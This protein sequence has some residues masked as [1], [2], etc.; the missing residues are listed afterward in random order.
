MTSSEATRAAPPA[1]APARAPAFSWALVVAVVLAAINL[2]TAVTS[3]G[4]LLDEIENGVG[5]SS[6]LAGVLTTM[7]VIS[8][9]T[10]GWVTPRLASRIGFH[11][12]MT[13]ALTMMTAGLVLRAL[14][15]SAWLFLA[16]SVLALAGGAMGNVLLPVM[17]K[18]H[19]PSRVGAM[20]ATY[21]TA[22]AI[23]TTVAAAATVPIASIGGHRD[24]LDWR[25]GVGS[26][27]ALSAVAA[28]V[29]LLL[30][31]RADAR[32]DKA[33]HGSR[34]LRSRTAW[35]LALFFG[36][37]SMQAYI[38]FGWFAQFFREEAHFSA[39]RAGL[40]IAVMSAFAIPVSIAVPYVAARRTSQRPLIAGFLTCY[41][42][43]YAGMLT[44]PR[45]G[46]WLWALLA[47]TGAGA[48][49]LA[50]TLIGLRSRTPS[51]TAALSAFT[52][53]IGYVLAG[54]GPL[55]VGV[56]HGAT[57][58]WTAPFGLLFADLVLLAASGWY[59]GKPRYVD[60]ELA[61]D[62]GL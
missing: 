9:A 26:W 29:W 57:G 20:T 28:L 21:T 36:A 58:G 33:T 8:F 61:D 2:R 59:I 5:L 22:L 38:A 27:A 6:G 44:A 11:R 34:L 16:L 51:T 12:L 30:P 13:A 40:L 31:N 37:Q 39:A 4:P 43:A 45:S 25:L 62:S 3:V 7:P 23:G 15:G 1:A 53:S 48:F 56:L 10:L 42:L 54:A 47:G 14:A 49:P 19:F 60:D 18:R 52:Q 24:R 55:L 17:V 50:L 46:A 32:G 35:A 41:V